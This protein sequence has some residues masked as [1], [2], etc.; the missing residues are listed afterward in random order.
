MNPSQL[1]YISREDLIQ[2]LLYFISN[3]FKIKSPDLSFA[4]TFQNAEPQNQE[5]PQ[6]VFSKPLW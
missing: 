6:A 1:T 5:C 2:K 4:I 3:I